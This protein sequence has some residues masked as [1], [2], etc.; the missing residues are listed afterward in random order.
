MHEDFSHRVNLKYKCVTL[1][2][3]IEFLTKF[4]NKIT[5]IMTIS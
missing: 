1:N 2:E 5:E 3:V 4:Q